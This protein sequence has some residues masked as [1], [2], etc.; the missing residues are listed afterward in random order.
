MCSFK[1]HN[2]CEC[3]KCFRTVLGL[4]AEVV[5]IRD[6]GFYI[7]KPLKEH[8]EDV[9]S[10]RAGLLTFKSDSKVHWPYII[11]RMKTNYDKMNQEQKDFV[12]W[13]LNFDFDKARREGLVKYYM[14]NFF[15]ILKKKLHL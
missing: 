5:D 7:D 4:T 2:C 15:K 13:F 14:K 3:E 6:F 9:M 11:S 10:R 8:W 12:D 1:G